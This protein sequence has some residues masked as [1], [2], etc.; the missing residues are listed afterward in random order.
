MTKIEC[1]KVLLREELQ[2]MQN[3]PMN[4]QTISEQ[5]NYD[6]ETMNNMYMQMVQMQMFPQT[7]NW[8]MNGSNSDNLSMQENRSLQYGNFSPIKTTSFFYDPN[9]DGYP[10]QEADTIPGQLQGSQYNQDRNSDGSNRQE[11]SEDHWS[12]RPRNAHHLTKFD[13]R[14]FAPPE[15]EKKTKATAGFGINIKNVEDILDDD[16]E[17][18]RIFDSGFSGQNPNVNKKAVRS[19]E[20]STYNSFLGT[21][22]GSGWSDTFTSKLN[23]TKTTG[24]GASS[25]Y[26][27]S[28]G[29][30]NQ[31]YDL[32]TIFETGGGAF[33][34]MDE[35]IQPK[36]KEEY[37]LDFKV[38]NLPPEEP[39]NTAYQSEFYNDS[40]KDK[41]QFASKN[42]LR[43]P[44]LYPISSKGSEED[45]NHNDKYKS[46][47]EF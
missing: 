2:N 4:P 47:S 43:P 14:N 37:F 21:N 27:R 16:D 19:V 36:K 5:V 29:S 25:F 26:Q 12:T 7:Q 22:K 45:K 28:F 10:D 13:L 42:F 30:T 23:K 41:G 34:T 18:D 24:T 15:V 1:R 20:N 17:E 8:N 3:Q 38:V 44:S 9:G 35:A 46:S 40:L 6:Q 11:V 31:P 39:K 32:N 33:F